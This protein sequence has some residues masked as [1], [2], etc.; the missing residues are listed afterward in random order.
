MRIIIFTCI[1][2]AFL[3]PVIHVCN[4]QC[5]KYVNTTFQ[6]IG[7]ALTLVTPAVHI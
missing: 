5:V 3:K 4:L 1:I 6:N 2:S 7:Y